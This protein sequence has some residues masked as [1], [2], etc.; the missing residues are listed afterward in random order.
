MDAVEA[1]LHNSLIPEMKKHAKK[2]LNGTMS[3]NLPVPKGTVN[4]LQ[5]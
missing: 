3:E 4:W 1:Y 2:A 5:N